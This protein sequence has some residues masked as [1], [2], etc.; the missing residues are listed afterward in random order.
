MGMIKCPICGNDL[1]LVVDT[2][3]SWMRKINKNGN[4][5]KT[6]N[7]SIGR[8]N[9]ASYLE[10]NICHYTYDCEHCSKDEQNK[11]L[12]EWID[13]HYDEIMNGWL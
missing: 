11:Q 13:E 9:G 8:P 7:K 10:C 3:G 1:E 12:D 5:H 6:I 2:V 4:L